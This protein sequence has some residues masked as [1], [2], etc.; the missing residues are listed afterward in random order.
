MQLS[1]HTLAFNWHWYK[2]GKIIY[3][4]T[5]FQ[6]HEIRYIKKPTANDEV[7]IE[8]PF[9]VK[10]IV[11]FQNFFTVRHQ[12]SNKDSVPPSTKSRGVGQGRYTTKFRNPVAERKLESE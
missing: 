9:K 4:Y 2:S 12:K 3:K 7:N 1:S 5:E 10:E 11:N 6:S 8:N